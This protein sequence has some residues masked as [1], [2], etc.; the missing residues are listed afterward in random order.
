MIN[1]KS[2]YSKMENWLLK[3]DVA[4]SVVKRYQDLRYSIITSP[5]PNVI[6]VKTASLREGMRKICFILLLM[7]QVNYG[8]KIF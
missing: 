8:K 5:I 3:T 1:L 7:S 2:F 6:S 4:L